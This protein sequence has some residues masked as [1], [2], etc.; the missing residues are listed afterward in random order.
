MSEV[1][2]PQRGPASA[3]QI[4]AQVKSVAKLLEELPPTNGADLPTGPG[5]CVKDKYAI[6]V[7]ESEGSLWYWSWTDA[8]WDKTWLRALA[9][10]NWR[11]AVTSGEVERLRAALIKQ[12][13]EIQ[14]T[15]GKALNYP[16]FS[17][18]QKNFPGATGDAVC[19]G[20]HVAESLASEAAKEIERLRADNAE[21]RR[22][23][24]EAK[25]ECDELIKTGN[26]RRVAELRREL[27][28]VMQKPTYEAL[29]GT[30]DRLKTQNASIRNKNN[31]LWN[32]I[33]SL[34]AEIAALRQ[35]LEEQESKT[36]DDEHLK[37]IE[38]DKEPME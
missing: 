9:P 5:V 13:H 33:K 35:Q 38:V 31:T 37:L 20:D 26:V 2:G 25:A 34:R 7:F 15:L 22:Q 36:L 28:A 10:G 6:V 8:G 30:C 18:D 29:R 4:E 27:E 32:D 17:D 19:I 23:V 3:H 14:Q 11:P 12:Q 24:E 16:K 1:I 21:L